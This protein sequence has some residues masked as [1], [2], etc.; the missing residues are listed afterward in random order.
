MS[1]PLTSD[2]LGNVLRLKGLKNVNGRRRVMGDPP[3]LDE[4]LQ[5]EPFDIRNAAPPPAENVPLP[6]MGQ[7]IAPESYD[8]RA[9]KVMTQPE[10]APPAP[11]EE[12]FWTRF[13]KS[14]AGQSGMA[15]KPQTAP[16]VETLQVEAQEGLPD[17]APPESEIQQPYTSIFSHIGNALKEYVQP[18]GTEDH[19]YGRNKQYERPV[20]N[21]QMKAQGI[22]NPDVH[23]LEDAQVGAIQQKVMQ[24]ELD[25]AQQNPM[26][27]IVYG[28]TDMAANSPPIQQ[29][30][31]KITGM[32]FDSQIAEQTSK[33]E[34]VLADIE[35]NNTAN[36]AA[37][38]EQSKRIK[39]R[40]ESNSATD[41]D[42][43][44]VGMALLMPLLV[45][46]FFGKDAAIGALAGGFKG[47]AQNYSDRI[48]NNREDE[49]LL[50]DVNKLKANTDLK[51][52]ELELEK[53]KFPAEIRKNLPKDPNEFLVGKNEVN[54]KD[55]ATGEDR[56]GIEI[57][58]G[59]IARPEFVTDKQELQEMRKEA[60]DIAEAMTPTQ[61]I[62]KLTK[63]I[64]FL[65]SKMK[66]KNLL[67]Q[68][69]S[70]YVAGKDMG[71]ATKLGEEIEFE[72]RKVNSMV[73][74]EHK[75]KLLTDAYRQAKGMRALTESV[76]EHIEG[77]FRNP[78][79][80]FQSYKDTIDQMLYTR[81][82]IQ[83]RLIKN[84]E[85]HG[86]YPDFIKESFGKEN[87]GVY[88]DLNQKE[89]EKVSSQL[90][91]D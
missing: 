45:G 63:D 86:F 85:S 65:A 36:M 23:R 20:Q 28:S 41:M 12:G 79:T 73:A 80:S 25:K 47:M 82:L 1:L 48:K 5:E 7:G 69:I 58:P 30:F 56:R 15:E 61:D 29:E 46:A 66:D 51:R 26:E 72:G 52:S 50:A 57:K 34:K 49:T 16:P 14:L 2:S 11:E 76:K 10:E 22:A 75:I 8:V 67:G 88:N 19:T 6:D 40:I 84:A 74:L 81:D 54:F 33:Y 71:L 89:G 9:N 21:A 68:A 91:R 70:S 77:L 42:K 83:N 53:L 38:D 27:H 78:S 87:K 62:N 59:L 90:L 31:K 37:Y 39:E 4:G 32:D 43:Y 64:V 60:G 17:Q 35:S 3:L 44:Y 24:E 55:P 18:F 13:G